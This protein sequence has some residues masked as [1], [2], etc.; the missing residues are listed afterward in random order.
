MFND[1]FSSV[2]LV[3]ETTKLYHFPRKTGSILI[4][5]YVEGQVDFK[6]Q[7]RLQSLASFSVRKW[8]T[9]ITAVV[10]I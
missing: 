1:I 10:P 3:L 6:W 4:L 5:Y 2:L 7:I 8:Y 9:S